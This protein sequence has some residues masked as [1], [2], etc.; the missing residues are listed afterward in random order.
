M[1][2]LSRAFSILGLLSL[3]VAYAP[4]AG[5]GS[6]ERELARGPAVTELVLLEKV[7]ELAESSIPDG[8]VKLAA[9][10]VGHDKAIYEGELKLVRAEDSGRIPAPGEIHPST[11]TGQAY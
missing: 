6:P 4:Q 1:K 2:A 9:D 10:G 3:S 11:V 5:A 7:L 8:R